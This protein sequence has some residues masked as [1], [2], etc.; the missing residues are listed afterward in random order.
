MWWPSV[1]KEE[2]WPAR[3]SAGAA[4]K[5]KEHP[6]F[7][8]LD[9]KFDLKTCQRP[10]ATQPLTSCVWAS[11][12]TE[13]CWLC[14]LFPVCVM[15]AGWRLRLF[16]DLSCMPTV[17]FSLR[18]KPILLLFLFFFMRS[19]SLWI[20]CAR[21]RWSWQGCKYRFWP[22]TVSLYFKCINNNINK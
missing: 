8:K 5:S 9:F 13:M 3:S 4:Q 18:S 2:W 10:T 17:T 22:K 16:K 14:D 20:L 12:E 1:R 6:W 15:S 19:R 11:R 7:I 21:T